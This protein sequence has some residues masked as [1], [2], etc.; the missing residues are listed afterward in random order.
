MARIQRIANTKHYGL[1]HKTRHHTYFLPSVKLPASC[2][3]ERARWRSPAP[4]PTSPSSP[5]LRRLQR[6][7]R[8]ASAPGTTTF[9]RRT[10][11]FR[12]TRPNGAAP[13]FQPPEPRAGTSPTGSTRRRAGPWPSRTGSSPGS[14]SGRRWQTLRFRSRRTQPAPISASSAAAME[15]PSRRF[16]MQRHRPSGAGPS[17]APVPAPISRSI[18]ASP[19]SGRSA[20]PSRRKAATRTAPS[21]TSWGTCWDWVTRVPTTVTSTRAPSSSAPTTPRC[22]R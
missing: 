12:R 18:P 5:K 6:W 2:N 14:H 11:P 13:P 15:A 10:T 20:A 9:P 19:V 21:S 17:V 7:R 4:I 1:R 8:P 22:G 16:R 3:L